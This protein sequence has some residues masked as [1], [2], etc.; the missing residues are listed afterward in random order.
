MTIGFLAAAKDGQFIEIKIQ[1]AH[2][3]FERLPENC[4]RLSVIGD[5]PRFLRALHVYWGRTTLFPRLPRHPSQVAHPR[6]HRENLH[7]LG[8][9]PIDDPIALDDQ[10]PDI[11]RLAV[12]F[13]D[14]PPLVR[15]VPQ[16]FSGIKQ[17]LDEGGRV[18][19]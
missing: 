1:D 3:H 14:F 5:R 4:S 11:L 19:R 2:F 12:G 15:E 13:R 8:P 10:L 17:P 7:D 9:R 6:H 18:L 16:S